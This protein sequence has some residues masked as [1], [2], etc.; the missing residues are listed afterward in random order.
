MRAIKK[1][2]AH[3]KNSIVIDLANDKKLYTMINVF[4]LVLLVAF[5]FLFYFLSLGLVKGADSSIFYYL[6]SNTDLPLGYELLFFPIIILVLIFHELIHGLFFYVFPGSIPVFGFKNLMAY[7]GVPDWYIKKYYYLII[8]V[9]PLIGITLLGFFLLSVVPPQFT[10]MVF[11]PM[12][13][14][15]AGCVGDIW[16]TLVIITKPKETYITDSGIVSIISYN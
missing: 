1:S 10:S 8:S 3:F 11:L 2:E 7:A 12:V 9:S 5:Y 15:A 6:R 16:Y 13:I 4:S 14:N